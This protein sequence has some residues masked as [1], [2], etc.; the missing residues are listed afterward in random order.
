M[1]LVLIEEVVVSPPVLGDLKG[2]TVT[3]YLESP[4][5]VKTNDRAT[6]FATSWHYGKNLGVVEIGRTTETAA[7]LRE[8]IAGERLLEHD[9]QVE[10][11]I[12]RAC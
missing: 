4:Q 6:F 8:S 10:E 12:R 11:R 7:G 5:G 9:E 1:A 2:K 3:V